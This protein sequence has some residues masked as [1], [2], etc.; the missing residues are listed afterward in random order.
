MRE[1][2][3]EAGQ[4]IALLFD[5]PKLRAGWVAFLLEVMDETMSDQEYEATLAEV[6]DAIDT[7]IEIGR[8]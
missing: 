2:L 1:A 8:W 6:R 7:R 4:A 5:T 3:D